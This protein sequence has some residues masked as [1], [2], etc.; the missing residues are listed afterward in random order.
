MFNYRF[1]LH[2]LYH[3][4]ANFPT[5]VCSDVE[6]INENFEYSAEYVCSNNKPVETKVLDNLRVCKYMKLLLD[7]YREI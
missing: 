3:L 7:V 4:D 2:I 1:H 6:C 5:G